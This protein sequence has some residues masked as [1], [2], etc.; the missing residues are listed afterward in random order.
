[1]RATDVVRPSRPLFMRPSYLLMLL[2]AGGVGT[3]CRYGLEER[4]GARPGAW[5]WATFVI[6]VVGSFLLGTLLT[7]LGRIGPDDGWRR[8]VRVGVG[9]GLIGGF[10]TYS[11][12][13][14]EVDKLLIG[15]RVVTAVA[16][17]LGSVLVGIAA[18]LAGVILV[19]RLGWVRSRRTGTAS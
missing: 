1:M 9:T 19:Q 14:V 17:S 10:T 12:F 16:Y 5:P 18:A 4:Y 2:V 3:A 15:G 11:T 13:I 6:N 7:A 8:R